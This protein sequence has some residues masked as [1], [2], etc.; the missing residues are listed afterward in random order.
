MSPAIPGG[1]YESLLCEARTEMTWRV[2]LSGEIHT[3]WRER[4]INGAAAS[5]LAVEFTSAVTN[6]EASD[7]AGDRLGAEDRPERSLLDWAI[8]RRP[9]RVPR[10]ETL[11][12]AEHHPEAW[13]IRVAVLDRGAFT[14]HPM[15]CILRWRAAAAQR[16][17][18]NCLGLRHVVAMHRDL[19]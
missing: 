9:P 10:H 15:L 18:D 1:R 3:D 17:G 8:R 16:V 19:G 14:L 11:P 7:A 4:I 12:D 13:L 6:H 5:G 2:Y